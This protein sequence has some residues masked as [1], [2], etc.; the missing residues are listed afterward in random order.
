MLSCTNGSS[1]SGFSISPAPPPYFSSFLSCVHDLSS[2]HCYSSSS[3][4]RSPPARSLSAV[5][6]CTVS[7]CRSM[8]LLYFI[9]LPSQSTLQELKWKTWRMKLIGCW[10]SCSQSRSCRTTWRETSRKSRSWSTRP[11]SRRTQWV[12]NTQPEVLQVTNTSLKRQDF[13]KFTIV[14]MI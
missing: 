5:M 6:Y 2:C 4:R 14:Y 12:V 11:G 10:R 7:M 9:P 8:S 13:C 3:P 1:L